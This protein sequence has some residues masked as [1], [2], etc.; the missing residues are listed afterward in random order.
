MHSRLKHVVLQLL[1]PVL[2][3]GLKRGFDHY[4]RG[5][6]PDAAEPSWEMVPDSAELWAERGGWSHVSIAETQR[7][8]WPDFLASVEGSHPLG[9]SHEAAPGT[10]PDIG[11]HNTIMSFG[12]ALGRAA[13]AQR[14]ISVLDWGGGIGH[15]FVYARKLHPDLE[16]DYV[17]KDMPG[18]CEAGRALLAGPSFV[19]DEALALTRRYDLVFASSSLHYTRDC[20]GLLDRLCASAARW[21][22][23][24]RTPFVETHDDF[25]VV[26]R[27]HAFGYMTE[28]PGWF[29]NRKRVVDFVTQRGMALER[30]FL[31]AERPYVFNAPEQA[32]YR[33]LLFRRTDA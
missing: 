23:V 12:Y 25:V 27:P 24:T 9:Q 16:M 7:R 31:V 13:A 1:P 2:A 33:G 30:E 8:K 19:S 22:M 14:R 26:Q 6:A 5:V 3:A 21:L 10:P 4:V 20:Y 29:L 28:Y 11:P 32:Q 18:L 15:Y 17:I